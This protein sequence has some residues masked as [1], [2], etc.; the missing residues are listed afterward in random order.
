MKEKWKVIEADLDAHGVSLCL[1]VVHF[2]F[3]QIF[4]AFKLMIIIS[5]D[6]KKEVIMQALMIVQVL[7]LP[8]ICM[9]CILLYFIFCTYIFGCNFLYL[10]C[11]FFWGAYCDVALLQK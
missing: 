9:C 8:L 7:M 10:S 5:M 4:S 1:V 11:M 6:R 2:V 3:H